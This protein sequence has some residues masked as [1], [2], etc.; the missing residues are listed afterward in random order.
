MKL[1]VLMRDRIKTNHAIVQVFVVPTLSFAKA[2]TDK[3][4][5]VLRTDDPA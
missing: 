4:P 5:L 3:D 2:S 1:T